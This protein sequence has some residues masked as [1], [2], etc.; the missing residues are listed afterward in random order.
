MN[1]FYC[2][3]HSKEKARLPVGSRALL[4][5]SVLSRPWRG[6]IQPGVAEPTPGSMGK[7]YLA[8]HSWMMTLPTSPEV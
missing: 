1:L 4:T 8:L 5:L 2:L 6:G 3:A 7:T